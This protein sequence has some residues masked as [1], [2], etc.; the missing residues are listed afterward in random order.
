[1]SVPVIVLG[2][3][4][5]AKVLIDALL[6]S[7]VEILGVTDTDPTR[8][9]SCIRG[10]RIVGDDSI[11]RRYAS[12]E[13]RLVNG[14]GSVGSTTA[15]QEIYERYKAL[16]YSFQ[17]VVHPSAVVSNDVKL[18]EGVQVMA[19]AIIQPGS[20]IGE[21]A[22]INTGATVDHDCQIGAHVH[23]APGVILSGSVKIGSGTHIGTGAVV[24][25]NVCVGCND[26]V[27]A[28]SVVV[29]NIADCKRVMGVP[30]RECSS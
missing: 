19:G 14:L 13:V 10:V 5:H 16:G 21:N 15:R 29:K 20:E 17:T 3:G 24:I 30:A 1:M 2:G 11:V 6:A 7:C 12:Q 27:G 18:S 8:V 4:G 9:D 23:L 22:V 25:Q 26:V 28:G